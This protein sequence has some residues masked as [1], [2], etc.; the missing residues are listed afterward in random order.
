VGD[1]RIG[2]RK[3][4]IGPRKDKG[5]KAKMM[6][7]GVLR[8]DESTP[9][10]DEGGSPPYQE[11]NLS[12]SASSDDDDGDGGGYQIK[13]SQP[14]IQFTG[15]KYQQIYLHSIHIILLSSLTQALIFSGQPHYTHATQDTDHGTPQSQRETITYQER[16]TSRGRG[17]GR[18]HYFSPADSS[19]SQNTSS[20]TFYAHGFDSYWASDLSQLLQN[21]QWVYE[22][23]NP[24]FYNVLV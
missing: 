10:P 11:S 3:L 8:S 17:R 22:Y 13:S 4:K 24:E 12:T 7:K 20:S 6:E 21:V 14:P 1:T 9:S 16:H 18:Q 15:A 19:S 2:K 23:E 5:K